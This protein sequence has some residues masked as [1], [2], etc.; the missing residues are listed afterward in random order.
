MAAQKNMKHLGQNWIQILIRMK[1]NSKW[2]NKGYVKTGGVDVPPGLEKAQKDALLCLNVNS[3]ALSL[4]FSFAS[5]QHNAYIFSQNF[6][7]IDEEL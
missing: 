5:L 2:W 1:Q 4:S 3:Q 7:P 6:L